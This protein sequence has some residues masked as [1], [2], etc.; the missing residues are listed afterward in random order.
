MRVWQQGPLSFKLRPSLRLAKE[1]SEL[2]AREA[3]TVSQ[4][5]NLTFFGSC[6]R[7]LFFLVVFRGRNLDPTSVSWQT[8]TVD[9]LPDEVQPMRPKDMDRWNMLIHVCRWW[10]SIVLSYHVA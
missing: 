4:I 10:Q 9:L 5:T 2:L 1:V 7:R 6:K 8:W 3:S